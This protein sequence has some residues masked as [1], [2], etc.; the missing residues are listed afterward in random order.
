MKSILFGATVSCVLATAAAAHDFEIG[1]LVIVH[2]MAFETAPSAMSGG[3]YFS[4][5]NNGTTAEHLLGVEAAFPRVMLHTT[6]MTDDIA[7]MSHVD[8]LEI[9]AGETVTLAPGGL[10]VMFMGLN[11]D[12]LEAGETFPATLIFETAGR[13][14]VVFNV[15]ARTEGG[16][17]MDHSAHQ[18]GN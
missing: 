4:I 9:P 2:P 10:H 6:E 7:R 5:T 18:M 13:L 17:Q 11:G 1:D 14:D 16:M 15:E 3:G 8:A 12:P